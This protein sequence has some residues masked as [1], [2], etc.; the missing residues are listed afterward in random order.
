[1]P[2]SHLQA[3]IANARKLVS[4]VARKLAAGRVPSP[5]IETV[6]DSA[7]ITGPE[8]RDPAIL[9]KLDA[10]AGRVLKKGL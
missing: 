5:A 2:T 7:F 10:V 8:K 3:N 1:M 4:G 9:A 6:L